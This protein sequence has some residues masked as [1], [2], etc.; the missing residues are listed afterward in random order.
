MIFESI[1]GKGE[2]VLSFKH[3]IENMKNSDIKRMSDKFLAEL[4]NIRAVLYKYPQIK[5][6][7]PEIKSLLEVNEKYRNIHKG[8]RC[9]IL[10]N[11]P[12]LKTDDLALLK[13]EIVF[14]VNQAFRLDQFKAIQSNYHFWA[15][16]VFFQLDMRKPED[17]EL[18]HI[19]R[20]VAEFNH[21]IEC[22]FPIEQ[23]EFVH[24]YKLYESF[25]V[26]YYYTPML[27]HEGFKGKFD[28]TR[29]SVAFYTV[30]QWAISMAIYMGFGEIY[31]L[32]CDCT[33]IVAAVK[34]ILQQN[35]VNEYGY[36]LD[37]NEKNRL[38]KTVGNIDFEVILDACLNQIRDY[39]RLSEYCQ[40]RNIC[41][42]NCSAETVLT[43]IPRASLI[44]VLEKKSL[45]I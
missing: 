6:K 21:D 34:S 18:L 16:P 45:K 32:G 7:M 25:N 41:L 42:I 37:Q 14:T 30:V 31:L 27:M 4:Y 38:K 2:N 9:F 15:D 1:K 23:K 19:M 33:S 29:P 43:S 5:K 22:F 28:F 11:G 26:N 24:K 44:D 39:R 10:G 8:K 3:K 13:D 36:Y 17:R 35:D 40:K 12:S 20:S